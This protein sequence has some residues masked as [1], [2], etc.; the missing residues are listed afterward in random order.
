MVPSLQLLDGVRWQGTPVPGGRLATLLSVLALSPSGLSDSVL[1]KEIWADDPPAVPTKALQVL[2]S[3]V[4]SVCG[5]DVVARYDGGYR[6]SLPDAEV[7][8][9][10]LRRLVRDAGSALSAGEPTALDLVTRAQLLVDGVVEVGADDG[11]QVA[12]G[13]DEP[14]GR[15]RQVGGGDRCHG[16]IVRRTGFRRPS[17]GLH[18]PSPAPY[19][20]TGPSTI[21]PQGRRCLCRQARPG[22]QMSVAAW[23][24]GPPSCCPPEPGIGSS[25]DRGQGTKSPCRHVGRSDERCTR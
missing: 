17:L 19:A 7:D 8:A 12:E 11:P 2:V 3:R 22:A 5:P 13:L 21:G 9:W 20:C 15:D 4:R 18:R 1:V 16:P 25:T 23:G 6:L 14:G 24:L 10:L